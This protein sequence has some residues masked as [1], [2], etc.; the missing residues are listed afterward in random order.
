MDTERKFNDAAENYGKQQLVR[1]QTVLT[2]I[3]ALAVRVL[4][5]KRAVRVS[6]EESEALIIDCTEQPI[7]RPSPK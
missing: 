1:R 3:E 4:F 7:Q 6:R 2:A 5:V